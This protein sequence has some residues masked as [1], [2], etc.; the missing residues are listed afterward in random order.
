MEPAVSVLNY[1]TISSVEGSK[2]EG[3][4]VGTGNTVQCHYKPFQ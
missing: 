4:T 3:G 2:G 1:I